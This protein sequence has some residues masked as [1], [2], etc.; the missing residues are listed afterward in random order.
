MEE[1][2]RRGVAGI[3]NNLTIEMA[4][5]EKETA[6]VLEEAFVMKVEQTG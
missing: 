1:E 6:E 4:A 3:L 5:P 2:D